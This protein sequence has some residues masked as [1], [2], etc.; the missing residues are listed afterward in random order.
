VC[1]QHPLQTNR[2]AAVARFRVVRF[3]QLAQRRLGC[4]RIHLDEKFR[5]A[6]RLTIS[7]EVQSTQPP[8]AKA[9]LFDQIDFYA[10]FV[11]IR[12]T[13]SRLTCSVLP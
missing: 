4:E 11:S 8:T 7:R 6:G 5:L 13:K 9:C 1:A 3:N 10:S 2:S 12:P